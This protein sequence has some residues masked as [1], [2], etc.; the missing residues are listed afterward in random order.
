MDYPALVRFLVAQRELSD[1]ITI[2]AGDGVSWGGIADTLLAIMRSG[3]LR[4]VLPGEWR[5]Q[6]YQIAFVDTGLHAREL[7][8]RSPT[9]LMTGDM[10][11]RRACEQWIVAV[12]ADGSMCVMEPQ[13]VRFV[14]QE[15]VLGV[16]GM[17]EAH[18]SVRLVVI[19]DIELP[20][21]SLQRILKAL[22]D[23]GHASFDFGCKGV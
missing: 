22:V 15:S 11:V 8:I 13:G 5:V 4:A 12:S 7:G 6:P 16:L 9:C 1:T 10:A 21:A 2:A 20:W 14:R 23:R 18:G 17:L 19:A 3:Y